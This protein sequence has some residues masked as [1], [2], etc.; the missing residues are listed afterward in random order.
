MTGTPPKVVQRILGHA[1][2]TVT[3]DLYGHLYPD[4][5][6]EW[7]QHLDDQLRADGGQNDDEDSPGEN[8]GP[9]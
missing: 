9:S 2:I 3:M 8:G 1:R 7:A 6:D 4:Q 5:R